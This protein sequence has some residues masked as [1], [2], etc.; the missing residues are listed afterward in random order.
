MFMEKEVRNIEDLKQEW[1]EIANSFDDY[2]DKRQYWVDLKELEKRIIA[3]ES[4]K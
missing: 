3:L 2:E 1:V 4:D